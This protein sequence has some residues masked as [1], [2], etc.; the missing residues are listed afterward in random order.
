MKLTPGTFAWLL[1]HD[2][3]LSW[4]QLTGIFAGWSQSVTAAFAAVAI[5]TMHLI[6][7]GVLAMRA[8][9]PAMFGPK[10]AATAAIGVLL[11]MVAQ[12]LL[13]ATRSLYERGD[14]DVLFASPLPEWKAVV[15]RALAITMS[16]M[17]ALAPM[18][19]PFANVAALTQDLSWLSLYPILL[20]MA[21]FGTA[22][23]F[24]I[25]IVLFST[26]GPRRARQISQILAAFI[27]GA[28]VL[29]VQIGMLLPKEMTAELLAWVGQ[30]RRVIAQDDGIVLLAARAATRGDLAMLLTI[31][32]ISSGF[33]ALAVYALS[34]AFARASLIASGSG[35]GTATARIRQR[36]FRPGAAASLRL[37]EWRLLVRDPN[38]FA[39]LGLQIIYTLPLAVM[40]LRRPQD[41]PPAVALA[42]LI[43]VL[44][45]QIS[46][47][48]AW[49]TVSGED[50]PELI[51]S[52][53]VAPSRAA[54]AKLSA[55][56]APLAL[57]LAAPVFA[58]AA[59]S[60]LAALYAIGF[61]ALAAASTALLNFWHP[62]QGNR[63]GL[64]RRHSQSKVIA[65]AE[66]GL[67]LLWA[68]AVVA[69]MVDLRL[70]L[71]PGVFI[72]GIIWLF[73]P[74]A[75][76]S[77]RNIQRLKF[78]TKAAVQQI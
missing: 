41:I 9:S 45:A 3:K 37:K 71:V 63:R 23:G 76:V 46:A 33:F 39:Q 21:L 72:A 26:A 58:L 40:L 15:S 27:A 42:P 2:L 12:G 17:A 55:I 25:A 67:A 50:A 38:L 64:L 51:A 35:S 75:N 61:G 20:S 16:T 24:I 49:I 56:A 54:I 10:T 30:V 48:L 6:A 8:T 34:G 69:A 74:R 43:V 1:A 47:S 32:V 66:H 59:I 78:P 14:L 62:M 53:P 13:G 70:A 65:I 28:F 73:F 19:S 7:W 22:S 29:A 4:R 52:A 60:F 5:A 36:G 18:I 77:R 44:A 68:M 11:W 57:I 31:F